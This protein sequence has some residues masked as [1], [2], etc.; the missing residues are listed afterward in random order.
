MATT[1]CFEAT[2]RLRIGRDEAW[3]RLTGAEGPV[4]A[5]DHIWMAAF[6]ST[7]TVV[8]ADP[9]TGSVPTR[10]TSPARAPTSS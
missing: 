6:D 5:G 10:T 1:D 4:A 3:Q 8:E 9:L 7:M 2:F